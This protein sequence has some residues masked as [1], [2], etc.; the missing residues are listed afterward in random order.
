MSDTLKIATITLNPAIDRTVSVP[1]FK[2]GKVNR[3]VH[4]QANAGGKGVNVASNLAD[5]GFAVT[6]TGFLGTENSHIFEQLFARKQIEDRFVRIEG[7]TRIGIKIIDE[8]YE[9]TTDIN[10]PGQ[11]PS[12]QDVS[13]LFDVVAA[14]TTECEWFVLSG[15]IPI[16]APED[17]YQKLIKVIRAGGRSV[18]L[19]TSGRALKLA[20]RA[21]PTL[22]KPNLDELRELTGNQI[23]TEAMVIEAA[24]Q[25][26][27]Q[28]IETVVVSLGEQ[29]AIY[30]EVNHVVQAIPPKVTVKSTVGAGDAMVSGTVA[31]KIKGLSLE[32]CARLAT[33][34]SISAIS[35]VG[36]GLPSLEAI[37]DFKDQVEIKYFN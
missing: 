27:D 29:G 32:E 14:L 37:E 11:T 12:D 4:E 24:R 20:L 2:I 25:L 34:F 6:V 19:D 23:K 35:Q 33:A 10:F 16:G 31:G 36:S 1:N 18:A 28:G 15:S 30:V 5:Y 9:E 22:I 8:V 26:L 21:A 3:V 13:Q 7:S 17:I